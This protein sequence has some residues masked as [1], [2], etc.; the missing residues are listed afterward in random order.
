M[1]RTDRVY[2]L[3]Q[4]RAHRGRPCSFWPG[5]AQQGRRDSDFIDGRN[6]S[7]DAKIARQNPSYGIVDNE[8]GD[9]ADDVSGSDFS[10]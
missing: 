7:L 1:R 10:R 8:P 4:S 6:E 3:N 5:A 2:V 9:V